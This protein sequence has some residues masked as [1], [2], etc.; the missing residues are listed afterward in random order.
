MEESA[1]SSRTSNHGLVGLV[2]LFGNCK[3]FHPRNQKAQGT[4]R[5]LRTDGCGWGA[6]RKD[7]S[8]VYKTGESRS[9]LPITSV[10]IRTSYRGCHP[11]RSSY[12]S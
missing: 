1:I 10:A 3:G 8:A 4:Y 9:V 6:P 11:R 12:G 7:R 2:E 5:K